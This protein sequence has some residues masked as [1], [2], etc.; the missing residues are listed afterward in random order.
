MS[1]LARFTNQGVSVQ[2]LQ[3]SPKG[4]RDRKGAHHLSP[5]S[6]AVALFFT[7]A[8]AVLWMAPLASAA[9]TDVPLATASSYAVLAGSTVTNTGPSVISGDI[10]LSPGSAVI[11]FPPGVQ[12]KGSSHV[13]DAP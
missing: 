13:A 6:A 12:P 1:E 4:F 11:G 5:V 10:G 7:S 9:T 2:S 3:N 8:A